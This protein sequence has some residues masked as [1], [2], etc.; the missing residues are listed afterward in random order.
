MTSRLVI[1][2]IRVVSWLSGSYAYSLKPA[3]RDRIDLPIGWAAFFLAS[4]L[5][6]AA[7]LLFFKILE[8]L[9]ERSLPRFILWMVEF[10]VMTLAV[11]LPVLFLF[12]VKRSKSGFEGFG[13]ESSR[14]PF[15]GFL[16]EIGVGL[17][18]Y[19]ALSVVYVPLLI[20]TEGRELVPHLAQV[21]DSL[22]VLRLL[23][24]LAQAILIGVREEILFRGWLLGVLLTRTKRPNLALL[25]STGIFALVHINQGGS[26]VA[27]AFALGYLLG[28]VYL[29]RKSLTA[30]I[31]LHTLQNFFAWLWRPVPS[32][33]A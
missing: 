2:I 14:G 18:T 20:L 21:W 27:A 33:W 12:L 11:L 8:V 31:T 22:S 19:A 3:G 30:P 16:G 28:W 32:C 4:L 13:F 29:W 10:G 25:L 17:K 1:R 6:V 26:V 15:F 5:V 24:L 23:C 9:S 7:Y